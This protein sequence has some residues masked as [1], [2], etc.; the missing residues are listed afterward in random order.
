MK[1][2]FAS[3]GAVAAA[4][5][6]ALTIAAPAFA[7]GERAPETSDAAPAEG[8]KTVSV[9]VEG[10]NC[11]SCTEK[12]RAALKKLDGIK[13]VRAGENKGLIVV[14]YVADKVTAEEIVKAIRAAGFKSH[15]A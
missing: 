12:I 8:V 14:D 3:L 2:S 5:T 6:L 13:A 4:A 10:V 7:C 9:A 1:P 15:V 11:G